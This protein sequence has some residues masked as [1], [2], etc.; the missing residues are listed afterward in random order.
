MNRIFLHALTGTICISALVGISTRQMPSFQG[1][2]TTPVQAQTR[3]DVLEEMTI[4]RLEDILQDAANDL[5][6][7]EGQWQLTL[8]G[9]SI[10][11][12]ADAA[13]NRMRIV[14]PVVAANTLS[15]Q[16]VQAML[17]ANF[18]ST[19]DARYAVTN[20]TVVA[21]FV[22]PFASLQ[23]ADLR[24]GL[25]QVANLA[26]NF[27]TSYSSGEL[28]FLPNGEPQETLPSIEKELGI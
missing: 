14:A 9:Q 17:V 16:Q 4:E 26:T 18:H 24:S 19:L 15:A 23:A 28:G 7:G 6:G 10:I 3:P 13:N 20:G 2:E 11:V 1:L 25:R 8:E 5:Q 22:H 21:V 12:L 27:G